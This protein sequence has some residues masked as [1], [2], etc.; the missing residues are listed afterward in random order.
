MEKDGSLSVLK[1]SKYDTPTKQDLNIPQSAVNLP[2]TLI[3]DRDVLLDNLK[4]RGFDEKWLKQQ[5]LNYGI[6]NEKD[7]FFAE[8]KDG[9]GLFINHQ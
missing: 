4:Q 9:E 7:I 6:D 5:L 8:W 2:I 1:K 3:I